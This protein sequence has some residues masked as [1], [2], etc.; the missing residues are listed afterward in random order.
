MN[1]TVYF[2]VTSTVY[3]FQRNFST[4]NFL[5][6]NLYLFNL[7]SLSA[8]CLTEIHNYLY[9]YYYLT[10]LLSIYYIPSIVLGN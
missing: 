3:Y 2:F 9:Y 6:F 4:Y 8:M 7:Q 5:E 1:E 10:H